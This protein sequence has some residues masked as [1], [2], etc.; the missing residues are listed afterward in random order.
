MATLQPD[1]LYQIS[2]KQSPSLVSQLNMFEH[3]LSVIVQV[4]YL[5]T[6]GG[7]PGLIFLLRDERILTRI[8]N[9]TVINTSN[10]GEITYSFCVPPNYALAYLPIVDSTALSQPSQKISVARDDSKECLPIIGESK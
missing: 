2:I 8:G 1:W 7:I 5:S 9:L 3:S 6:K 10:D 4:K